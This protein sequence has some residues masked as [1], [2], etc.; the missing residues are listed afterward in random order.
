MDYLIN[1][2]IACKGYFFEQI[3]FKTKLLLNEEGLRLIHVNHI[4]NVHLAEDI[5]DVSGSFRESS[6]TIVVDLLPVV[7][8]IG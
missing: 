4:L 3:L 1:C 5:F 8:E 7:R 6:S 2:P